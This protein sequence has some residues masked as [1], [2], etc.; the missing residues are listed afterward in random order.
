MNKHQDQKQNI[1]LAYSI[2]SISLL[3][4]FLL[5]TQA[6]VATQISALQLTNHDVIYDVKYGPVFLDVSEV[7]IQVG[8]L[9]ASLVQRFV[10]PEEPENVIEIPEVVP[11]HASAP[12]MPLEKGVTDFDTWELRNV[13][14]LSIPK[15]NVHTQ[16]SLPSKTYWD[17][18]EW[19]LLEEQMQVGLAAG[20]VAYPHSPRP[21]GR[22][23]LII[24][25]H[26]SPPDERARSGGHGRLFERL[27]E[28]DEG[29]TISV[30]AGSKFVDYEVTG[31]EI[32]SP[33]QTQI[34][35]QQ[36]ASAQLKLITCY[37]IGS[38]RD[39]WVVTAQKVE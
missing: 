18:K 34:L 9:A 7:E 22:G 11:K 4:S 31:I 1:A 10:A 38:T 16:V 35:A 37:P 25:G 12:E 13:Y 23:N 29:D 14:N 6:L 27:P 21:G 20:A 32:V 24:A 28:L 33:S 19:E 30:T 5:W 3:C 17:A 26:S 8:G 36:S 2:A 15:I 39:R